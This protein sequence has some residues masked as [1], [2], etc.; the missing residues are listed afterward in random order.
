VAGA[1]TEI[2]R[3]ENGN[4]KIILSEEPEFSDHE[5]CDTLDT[6]ALALLGVAVSARQ[7]RG[8]SGLTSEI[9]EIHDSWPGRRE[10]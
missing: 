5:R 7:V 2:L 3:E 6:A 9:T 1:H 4:W 8:I 10:N